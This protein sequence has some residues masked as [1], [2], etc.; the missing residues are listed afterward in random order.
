VAGGQLIIAHPCCRPVS[1]LK[2]KTPWKGRKSG[3]CDEK[4]ADFIRNSRRSGLKTPDKPKIFV[5]NSV[6]NHLYHQFYPVLAKIRINPG[7]PYCTTRVEHCTNNPALLK[8]AP[9]STLVVQHK[10]KKPLTS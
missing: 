5:K 10:E 6:R 3:L 8:N 7:L 9:Q 2:N 1:A 4:R